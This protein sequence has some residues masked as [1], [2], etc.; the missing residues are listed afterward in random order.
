MTTGMW[1]L[2]FRLVWTVIACGMFGWSWL[3]LIREARLN[4]GV[5]NRIL[6]GSDNA[7]L[8]E[9]SCLGYNWFL[10][11]QLWQSFSAHKNGMELS[12]GGM[13]TQ[14]NL[15]CFKRTLQGLS[16]GNTSKQNLIKIDTPQN[17]EGFLHRSLFRS[18]GGFGWVKS[19]TFN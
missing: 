11:R 3:A 15:A 19:Y 17:P 10:A 14:L 2:F 18:L 12:F 6:I 7:W 8:T 13:V 16:A 4:T 5:R 9:K 1:K